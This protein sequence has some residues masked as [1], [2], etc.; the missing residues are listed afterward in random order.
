MPEWCQLFFFRLVWQSGG[1]I[2]FHLQQNLTGSVNDPGSKGCPFALP[3]WSNLRI[4]RELRGLQLVEA[5]FAH[6][7]RQR[8]YPIYSGL[9]EAGRLKTQFQQ[10]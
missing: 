4:K 6:K 7:G 9:V 5:D 3:I 8:Q 2:I 1:L 10:E